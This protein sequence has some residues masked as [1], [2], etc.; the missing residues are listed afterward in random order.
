MKGICLNEVILYNLA[1]EVGNPCSSNTFN[2]L[3]KFKV[4]GNPDEIV[5]KQ[6][7]LSFYPYFALKAKAYIRIC[8][9]IASNPLLRVG[10][11]CSFKPIFSMK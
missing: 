5:S 11:K 3:D 8:F 6:Q 2:A 10:D 7:R 9:T 1:L 4:S